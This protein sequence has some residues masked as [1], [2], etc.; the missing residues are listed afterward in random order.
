MLPSALTLLLGMILSSPER[1][2][3]AIAIA[4]K[5]AHRPL[6]TAT[7]VPPALR[8]MLVRPSHRVASRPAHRACWPRYPESRSLA[9]RMARGLDSGPYGRSGAPSELGRNAVLRC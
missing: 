4:P 1:S 5:D 9:D 3:P 7:E 6:A 8:S 2:Q